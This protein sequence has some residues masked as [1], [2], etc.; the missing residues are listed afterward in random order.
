MSTESNRNKDGLS[1]DDQLKRWEQAKYEQS[2]KRRKLRRSTI[3]PGCT[4]QMMPYIQRLIDHPD[5]ELVIPFADFPNNARNTVYM[6]WKDSLIYLLEVSLSTTEAE[7]KVVSWIKAVCKTRVMLDGIHVYPP[8]VQFPGL[9]LSGSVVSQEARKTV[10]E[11]TRETGAWREEF[12]DFVQAGAT[13]DVFYRKGLFTDGDVAFVKGV[14][15]DPEQFLAKVTL[16]EIRVTK[17]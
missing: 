8:A 7:R 5:Q 12:M 13:G 16:T 2:L 15:S 1:L 4:Q 10:A 17:V 11:A 3:S 9:R 6:K 14:C